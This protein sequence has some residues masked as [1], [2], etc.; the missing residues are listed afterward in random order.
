MQTAID[1]HIPIDADEK[2]IGTYLQ[3]ILKRIEKDKETPA[4]S[5]AMHFMYGRFLLC[6]KEFDKAYRE[7]SASST[8]CIGNGLMEF[9]EIPFWIGKMAEM[10]KDYAR[11]KSCY[12]MALKECRNNPLFLSSD[13]ILDSI[14]NL[15]V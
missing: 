8:L 3:E 10:K 5:S 12:Y 1:K 11:A 6:N 2:E 9:C 14:N 4:L 15:R 7:F 13:D